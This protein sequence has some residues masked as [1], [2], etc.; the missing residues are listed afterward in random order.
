MH[1]SG[2]GW[3]ATPF[4]CDSFIHDSTPVLSRR[5]PRLLCYDRA[6]MNITPNLNISTVTRANSAKRGRSAKTRTARCI[7]RHPDTRLMTTPGVSSLPLFHEMSDTGQWKAPMSERGRRSF[8]RI[9]ELPDGLATTVGVS[10][11]SRTIGLRGQNT[12]TEVLAD[13]L[14]FGNAQSSSSKALLLK[15]SQIAE[16]SS[17]V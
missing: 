16:S 15:I 12:S 17:D 8:R 3:V 10:A 11:F 5:T 13:L 1:D 4:L 6:A 2:S 14:S 7:S 9:C